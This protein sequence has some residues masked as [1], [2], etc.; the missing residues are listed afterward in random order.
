MAMALIARM[1]L[2]I[3]FHAIIRAD[4]SPSGIAAGAQDGV[5]KNASLIAVKVLSCIGKTNARCLMDEVSD[6]CFAIDMASLLECEYYVPFSLN[7][8]LRVAQQYWSRLDHGPSS[9]IRPS[10]YR[11]HVFEC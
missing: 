9:S 5:G 1:S 11:F 3:L 4:M 8:M 2:S 7:S 6:N 10:L